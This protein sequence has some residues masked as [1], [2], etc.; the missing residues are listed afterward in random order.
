MNETAKPR[1]K[2]INT[3]E[4]VQANSAW[5]GTTTVR[6]VASYEVRIT[7][8]LVGTV[9]RSADGT[10]WVGNYNDGEAAHN[11]WTRNSTAWMLINS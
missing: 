3:A 6:P 5:G 4:T 8:T 2:K 7:G 1:F 10:T 11:G 9:H